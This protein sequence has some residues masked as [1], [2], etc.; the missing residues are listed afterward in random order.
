MRHDPLSASMLQLTQAI[1]EGANVGPY[2]LQVLVLTG[3]TLSASGGFGSFG[4]AFDCLG[5]TTPARCLLN[6]QA[7]IQ[8]LSSP[9]ISML[10]CHKCCRSDASAQEPLSQPLSSLQK[11]KPALYWSGQGRTALIIGVDL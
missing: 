8:K 3:I 7:N 9:E 4:R 11:E 10:A 6:L 2:L 1:P 5:P